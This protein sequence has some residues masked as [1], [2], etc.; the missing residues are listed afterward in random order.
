MKKRTIV[1]VSFLAGF[2]LAGI[3]FS[4]YAMAGSTRLTPEGIQFSDTTYQ[5][6]GWLPFGS[7]I[8]Y[9]RGNVG[10]GENSPETR[11]HISDSGSGNVVTIDK[12]LDG[13]VMQALNGFFSLIGWGDRPG[14]YNKLAIRASAT[15]IGGIYLLTNGKVGIGTDNP[16]ATLHVNVNGSFIGPFPKP[17][18]NS[19]WTHVPKGSNLM[20][21]H[22]LGGSADDY[23]VDM[24]CKDPP[25]YG[26]HATDI[27]N[28]RIGGDTYIPGGGGDPVSHGAYWYGLDSEVIIV[29][30]ANDDNG[31]QEVRV[32]IW[33]Y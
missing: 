16:E 20:F 2:V 1:F 9:S 30:R 19:L 3:G 22:N 25:P 11:L 5:T 4:L 28:H 32:R 12:G 24:T 7:D 31:C 29:S 6:T 27:N 33:V 13:L 26:G 8:Y 21:I 23:V 17:A 10:I 18:Y 15:N 14:G